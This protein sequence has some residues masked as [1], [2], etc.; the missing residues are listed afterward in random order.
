MKISLFVL[1]QQLINT[2]ESLIAKSEKVTHLT[3]HSNGQFNTVEDDQVDV[4]CA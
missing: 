3:I 4:G 2:K 1:V